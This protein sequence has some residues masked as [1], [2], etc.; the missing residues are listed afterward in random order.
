MSRPTFPEGAAVALIAALFGS[1]SFT[2]LPGLLGSASTL[3]LTVAALGLGY[4]LYLLGR[5][6]ERTGRVVA[7]GAWLLFAG[8]GLFLVGDPLPYLAVHLGMVWLVRALYHQSGP[9]A[10]LIDL[11]LNLLALAAG[12]WAFVHTSSTFL[13][14]WTFFL[15]QALFV[16]IPSTDGRDLATNPTDGGQ[17][18]PFQTAYRNAEAALRKL[19]THP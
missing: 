10:A 5:T 3:Q 12:V 16:A 13:G 8:L 14:I 19:S 7:L 9:L 15:V 6:Q 18:D 2:V 11:T 4:V 17:P 1:I